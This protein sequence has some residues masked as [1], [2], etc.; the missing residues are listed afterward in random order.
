MEYLK[1]ERDILIVEQILE[2]IAATDIGMNDEQSDITLITQKTI[3]MA[4]LSCLQQRQTQA[5]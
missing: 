2:Q 1:R 4:K 3:N 5:T